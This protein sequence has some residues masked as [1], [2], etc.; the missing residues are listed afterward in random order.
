MA[1]EKKFLKPELTTPDRRE[2]TSTLAGDRYLRSY[3]IMRLA[4]GVLGI[5][6]PIVLIIVE[7]AVLAGDGV[8]TS[9]SAYYHSGMR[10]VF[11]GTLCATAVFL[12]TYKV[13]EAN[14]DNTLSSLA[15]IAA[16]GVAVFPTSLPLGSS[17]V[18][19][20]WQERIGEQATARIHYISAALFIVFLAAIS[21]FFGRR[22]AN[23]PR[24]RLGRDAKFSGAAWRKFHIACAILIAIEAVLTWA[25]VTWHWWDYSLI[26]GETA[27]SWTFGAS[28]FAK[29]YELRTLYRDRN[30]PMDSTTSP[31]RA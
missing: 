29:G 17:S 22:E 30:T 11:V 6:L 9:L 2:Q 16:F 25:A 14:L 3:L 15:G 26:A 31:G 23:R 21:Y 10:D 12:I 5:A 7:L 28:W 13:A 1:V 20:P 19:T 24:E 8:R 4:I 27:V 18:L